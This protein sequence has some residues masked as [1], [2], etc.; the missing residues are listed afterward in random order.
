MSD[1]WPFGCM[2]WAL[3]QITSTNLLPSHVCEL[4]VIK[5]SQLVWHTVI[6]GC[7]DNMF[8]YGLIALWFALWT[9]A[10]STKIA[11]MAHFVATCCD[12]WIILKFQECSAEIIR[13]RKQ[14]GRRVWRVNKHSVLALRALGWV[15]Y[16]KA[17]QTLLFCSFWQ[18]RPTP[19]LSAP[20]HGWGWDFDTAIQ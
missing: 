19:S 15:H 13:P 3:D 12:L 18:V 16:G 11:S 5:L 1:V 9:W 17:C 20:W 14:T 10:L 2:H 4:R 7:G 8:G 6:V